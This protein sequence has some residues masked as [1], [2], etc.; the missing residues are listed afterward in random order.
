MQRLE[1]LRGRL[2]RKRDLLGK[3][4]IRLLLPVL[5]KLLLRQLHLQGIDL[6]E[7]MRRNMQRNQGLQQHP[8]PDVRVR[9]VQP[10]QLLRR[11]LQLLLAGEDLRG[12]QDERLLL[13]GVLDS[14][15]D[16][17]AHRDPDPRSR[18][19]RIRRGLRNE[20]RLPER[21]DR[22]G[23]LRGHEEPRRVLVHEGD[24]PLNLRLRALQGLLPQ[25]RDLVPTISVHV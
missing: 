3:H 16:P 13:Q 8:D 10:D 20:R 22:R 4:P 17:Q 24:R 25:R 11:Q 12:G 9:P 15:A 5:P 7:R 2:H 18:N 21:P 1:L 6:L 19:L 23:H 14:D